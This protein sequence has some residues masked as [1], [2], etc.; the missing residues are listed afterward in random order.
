MLAVPP[1]ADF[2]TPDGVL[3]QLVGDI[4]RFEDRFWARQPVHVTE[5]RAPVAGVFADKSNARVP[6]GAQPFAPR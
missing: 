4:H 3:W 1:S 5:P 6:G 2:A